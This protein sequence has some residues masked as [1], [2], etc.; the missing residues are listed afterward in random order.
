MRVLRVVFLVF[1]VFFFTESLSAQSEKEDIKKVIKLFFKGLQNGDTLTLKKTIAQDIVL[2][3]TFINK[4]GASEL[5]T[6]DAG[7]FLKALASKKPEDNWQEKLESYTI[8]VDGNMANVWTPYKFYLNYKF[9][10][11]GVNSFQLFNNGEKWVIIY[12]IDTRRRL[13]CDQ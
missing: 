10:H 5:R 13:G 4:E 12:L 9:S 2:Q 11:C 8:Q 3:T 1:C 7:N 6:E